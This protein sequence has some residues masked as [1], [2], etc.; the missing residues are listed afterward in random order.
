MPDQ[1]QPERRRFIQSLTAGATIMTLGGIAYVAAG[2]SADEQAGA[3]LRPDGR[4]RLP[5]GQRTLVP[6]PDNSAF[7]ENTPLEPPPKPKLLRT[8]ETTKAETRL[9]PNQYEIKALRPMGGIAGDPSRGALRLK[10]H[11]EVEQPLN[12]SFDNLLD[13]YTRIEQTCD[14]HCVTRWSLLGGIWQGVRV[15]EL[16]QRAKI[17]KR[18]RYVIFQSEAGYTANIDID[19][20]LKP[21]VLVAW[22]I[23][24][25]PLGGDHGAPLRSLVPDRYFWKSAKWL[26][27]IHFVESDVRGYWESRGYHNHADPWKEQRYSSQEG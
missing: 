5:P 17:T 15:G 26:T 22:D 16:A 21:N 6:K 11:G 10:V 20:A 18:A 23:N 24:G 27:G 9:P 7:G 25:A 3:E 4:R 19:E 12:L 8:D 14:V 1:P 2:C 13:D